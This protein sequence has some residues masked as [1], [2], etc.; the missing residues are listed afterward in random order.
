MVPLALLGALGLVAQPNGP[1]WFRVQ[2]RAGPSSTVFEHTWLKTPPT[3]LDTLCG[4]NRFCVSIGSHSLWFFFALQP[5]V[6]VHSR[7]EETLQK[8]AIDVRLI[9]ED[10]YGGVTV[11]NDLAAALA[12]LPVHALEA[13]IRASALQESAPCAA[14]VRTNPEVIRLLADAATNKAIRRLGVY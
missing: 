7:D 2:L 10:S 13:R 14:R 9:K 12:Q 11:S 1:S 4:T 3:S 5:D 8:R 6:L